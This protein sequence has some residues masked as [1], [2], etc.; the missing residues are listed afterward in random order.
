MSTDRV[1]QNRNVTT[2]PLLAPVLGRE[3]G[4]CTLA[5]VD[6]PVTAVAPAN[7]IEWGL[8]NL[9]RDAPGGSGW[10]PQVVM[11]TTITIRI[12]GSATLWVRAG[13]GTNWSPWVSGHYAMP[14]RSR[15]DSYY[16]SGTVLAD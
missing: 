3:S 15:Y 11:N 4:Q 9:G 6:V 7:R 2:P 14:R 1:V 10:S 5:P 16:F 12:Q 8:T 13:D